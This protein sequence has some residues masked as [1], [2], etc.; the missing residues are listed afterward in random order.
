MMHRL[1]QTLHCRGELPVQRATFVQIA[2]T[3]ES[4]SHASRFEDGLATCIQRPWLAIHCD[5][6]AADHL[7]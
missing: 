6:K 1:V 2:A 5:L 4:S 3:A 7:K